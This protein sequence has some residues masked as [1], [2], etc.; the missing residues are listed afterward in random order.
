MI[1]AMRFVSGALI[2]FFSSV[3]HAATYKVFS[4]VTPPLLEKKGEGVAGFAG[5]FGKIVLEKLNQARQADQFEVVWLPW[6]RALSETMKHRNGI[7]FPIARTADREKD[8]CWLV[9]LGAVESWFYATNPKV[10]INDLKDLKKYRVGFLNGSQR[11]MELRKI[12]GN[13]AESLEGLTEDLG[14]YRKLIS[15]RIDVWATQTEVFDK[16]EADYRAANKVTPKSYALKKFL[17]QE[18][19]LV[20]N[21]KM[22]EKL[23]EQIR[24]IFRP[25]KTESNSDEVS[26]AGLLSV[27]R[28]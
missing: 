10:K 15:G 17:D 18:V 11:A 13:E 23:Q 12:F 3:I 6:K 4:A 25:K 5:I 21:A 26:A 22:E 1:E 14:N 9:H 7:F 16:A 8:Y 27:Y 24:T 2:L 19:W 28:L 20:G